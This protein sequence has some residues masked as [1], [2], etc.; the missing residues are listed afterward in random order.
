M[1]CVKH[2]IWASVAALAALSRAFA[3][4]EKTPTPVEEPVPLLLK[5]RDITLDK[6]KNASTF[7]YITSPGDWTLSLEYPEDTA[8]WAYVTPESGEKTGIEEPK[9]AIVAASTAYGGEEPRSVRVVLQSGGETVSVDIRQAGTSG[10]GGGGEES[11]KAGGWI[12]LPEAPSEDGIFLVHDMTGQPYEYQSKSGIRNWS[13][14]WLPSEHESRWVAYPL[15]KSLSGSGNYGYEWGY[16]PC[17]TTA[18]QPDITSRS[19][20]G[21]GFDGRNNWNRGHQLPRADRQTSQAAVA[22]TCYPTNITPQDG[23]FNSGVWVTLETKV[24]AY[25]SKSDTL[26]VV[27]GCELRNSETYTAGYSGFNVRVPSAYWKAVV[28]YQKS[29]SVYGGYLGCAFYLPHD[30]SISKNSLF[31][32]SY[33]MSIDQLEAKIGLDL[34]VNLP[35][36]IGAANADAMEAVTPG[37]FWK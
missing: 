32:A 31:D 11:S 34:F 12:E 36:K 4:C 23:T 2:S 7:L 24:R 30:P 28:S 5:A 26:Y 25:A 10:S 20:G 3:S 14:C 17:T 9:H 35:A 8:P 15:N 27:T 33:M 13:C 21:L 1:N 29:R 6:A 16:D 19:Y 22:S 18:T 37:D